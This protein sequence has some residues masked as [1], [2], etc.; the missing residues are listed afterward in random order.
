MVVLTKKLDSDFDFEPADAT[1]WTCT[2]GYH[3]PGVTYQGRLIV[4]PLN[5]FSPVTIKPKE[6]VII[7]HLIYDSMLLKNTTKDT[8][9]T[10]CYAISPEWG[11]RFATWSGLAISKPFNVSIN[12]TNAPQPVLPVRVA[13]QE[14]ESRFLNAAKTAFKKHDANALIAM[15]CWDR[16]P[17]KLKDSGK[18][19]YAR[20]VAN[21]ATD[22]TLINP[23]P[24][25]PDI[26]WEDDAGI[27]YRSNLPVI[28]QLKVTFATGEF[29]DGT[30]PVGEK[31]GKLYL[32]A[33]SACKKAIMVTTAVFIKP[34]RKRGQAPFCLEYLRER[35]HGTKPKF[36][37]DASKKLPAGRYSSLCFPSYDFFSHT[38]AEYRGAIALADSSRLALC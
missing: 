4:P 31:D 5:E 15:T 1:K 13:F 27:A 20:D 32:L 6:E 34:D 21:T 8:Q 9:I 12:D 19:Q 24:Q 35:N 33:T 25:F 38:F 18:Q 14:E 37:D 10:V 30:Y 28:K 7:T 36:Y 22:V 11:S 17:D 26:E 2:L 29:S 23:Y 3:Q 16:V